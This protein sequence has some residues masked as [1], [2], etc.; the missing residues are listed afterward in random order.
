MVYNEIYYIHYIIR[1]ASKVI[2]YVRE[3]ERERKRERK[4]ERE[5][6]MRTGH[7]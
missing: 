5:A 1:K 7:L 2:L 6:C 3:K 4:R